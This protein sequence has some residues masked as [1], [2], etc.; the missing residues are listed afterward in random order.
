MRAPLYRE[1]NACT[2]KA[3]APRAPGH[4]SH[5]DGNG[6]VG[7]HHTKALN[8]TLTLSCT[9][10]TSLGSRTTLAVPLPR[11]RQCTKSR[12]LFHSCQSARKRTAGSRCRKGMSNPPAGGMRFCDDSRT[13]TLSI[14]LTVDNTWTICEPPLEPQLLVSEQSTCVPK[15][16]KAVALT[17][18]LRANKCRL[19]LPGHS[20]Q[21]WR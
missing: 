12:T 16:C 15:K 10:N 5:N 3:A 19:Q 8:S 20:K 21:L 17:P 11:R 18:A 1:K 6:D 2:R 9:R 7:S 13:N 14:A 4:R